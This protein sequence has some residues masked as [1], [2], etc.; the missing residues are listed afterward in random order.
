MPANEEE[1]FGPV[2]ALIPVADEPAAIAAANDARFGLGA[3]VFTR[4]LARGRRI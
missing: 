3:A 1:L 4:D 2:A